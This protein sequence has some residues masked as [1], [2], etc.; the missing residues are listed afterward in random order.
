MKKS[1][2]CKGPFTFSFER[3]PQATANNV[4]K[5]WECYVA[6]ISPTNAAEAFRAVISWESG[7]P[8]ISWEPDLNDGGTKQERIY[9]ILGR[10]SLT[11]GSWGPTNAA[12][13]FFKVSVEMP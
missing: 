8:A 7:V 10:E 13:R 6:G 5:V 3:R 12:S 2:K 11:E 9:T 4:N 1:G